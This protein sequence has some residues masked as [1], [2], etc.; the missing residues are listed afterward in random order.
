MFET[1]KEFEKQI[2]SFFGAPYAVATDC[3]THA[4]E[5]SLRLDENQQVTCPNHTYLSIPMTFCKLNLAWHFTTNSWQDYYSIGDSRIIDGAV[6]WQENSYIPDTL[7][8]L[9]FQFKKHLSLGRGGAILC[10]KQ[11]E[12]DWLKKA[13]YDG[14]HPD[15]PWTGQNISMLGFHYYMTPETASLGLNK[16]DTAI[17]TQPQ[18]WSWYDYPNLQN[19][20]VFR[21]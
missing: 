2:A 4:I 3:C 9:S 10:S 16:L 1:V 11:A 21:K 14:R 7:M 19:M 12:Y 13:S 20:D 6:L 5:L 17:H 8:C 15:Y 18:R